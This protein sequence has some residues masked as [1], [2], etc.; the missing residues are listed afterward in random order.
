MRTKTGWSL[1]EW[2]SQAESSS[3]FDSYK[4]YIIL[5]KDDN[6]EFI[7]IGRTFNTVEKRFSE[8]GSLPYSYEVLK[9]IVDNPYRI[10]KLESKLKRKFKEYKYIPIKYF[11]GK[12]ECFTL[13][14]KEFINEIN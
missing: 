8:V 14:I 2:I 1:S 7:K 13:D 9:V 12:H 4:I 10:F 3:S 11:T 5:V 6:E